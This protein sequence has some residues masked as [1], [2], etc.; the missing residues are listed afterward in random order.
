MT[1]SPGR[2]RSFCGFTLLEVLVAL[3]VL[4]IS[5]GALIK[6]ASEHTR[7]TA[8]LQDRTLAHWVA[9]NLMARYE[10]GLFAVQPGQAT[11]SL[12]QAERDWAYRVDIRD[13]LP[14]GEF[15]FQPVRRVEIAVWPAS[16]PEEDVRARL[17]GYLLP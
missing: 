12:R 13:M 16:E 2:G 10:A 6:A 9:Q 15:E 1:G 14:Q 11:G 5:L 4:T 3:T 7:N 8:Y 17:V